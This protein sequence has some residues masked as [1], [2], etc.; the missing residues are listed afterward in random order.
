VTL[1][2]KKDEENEAIDA[3]VLLLV[4]RSDG[5]RMRVVWSQIG[6]A[7]SERQVDRS[8]Q[9]LRRRGLIEY[10]GAGRARCWR[11]T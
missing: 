11:A 1:Q 7:V 6:G 2:A 4:K 9:R 3:R 5:T 10:N 8:L